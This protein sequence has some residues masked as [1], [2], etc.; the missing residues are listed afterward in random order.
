MAR[1]GQVV[2]VDQF[3]HVSITHDTHCLHA[4]HNALPKKKK[5]AARFKEGQN[6]VCESEEL[7]CIFPCVLAAGIPLPF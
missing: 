5:T 7:Q 6:R 2:V 4:Y 1:R 3:I